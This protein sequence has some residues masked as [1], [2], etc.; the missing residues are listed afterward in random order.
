V[1]LHLTIAMKTDAAAL[2]SLT[3]VDLTGTA[4][5][6]E[7]GVTLEPIAFKFFGGKYGGALS[8]AV[9]DPVKFALTGD[10]SGIDMT[11]VMTYAGSPGTITGRLSGRLDFTGRGDAPSEALSSTSGTAR[12]DVVDGIVSDLGLVRAIVIAGSGRRDQREAEL[13]PRHEPFTRIG[14]TLTVAS[15]VAHTSDLRLE[16]KDLL[17]SAAGMIALDGTSLDLAGTVHLSEALAA[18]AGRD[19]V[20]YTKVD[21]RPTM[22]VRIS[23]PADAPRVSVDVGGVL[24]QAIT[25]KAK[26][27]IGS[28]IKRGLGGLIRSSGASRPAYASP[29][30]SHTY[31]G[32]LERM[33]ST[34]LDSDSHRGA[35]MNE[36][37]E[38]QVL[39]ANT[40]L[41]PR[42]RATAFGAVAFGALAL[43][44]TAIGA[45]AIGRLAVGAMAVKRGRIHS[46]GVDDL[47]VRRL[48]V[49]E[50]VIDSEVRR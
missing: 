40:R 21:G 15:G 46:L 28:T 47:D 10:V 32:R 5:I 45:L 22:P 30:P 42:G 36:N 43:G 37:R 16:S 17:L 31:T 25:N 2:G 7:D 8:L 33:H 3:L 27:E 44:A 35:Y 20:R 14:A 24:R 19:L 48:R 4:T 26:E 13:G 38:E 50:L 11:E 41:A 34:H 23:G 49:R 6:T 29:E 39:A 18:R 12:I 1:P 9:S